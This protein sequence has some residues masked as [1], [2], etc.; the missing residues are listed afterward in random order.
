[1]FSSPERL[2]K[3][4][5]MP[6]GISNMLF[7]FISFHSDGMNYIQEGALFTAS[8]STVLRSDTM[9]SKPICTVPEECWSAQIISSDAEWYKMTTN[10]TY[11]SLLSS[12]SETRILKQKEEFCN[13]AVLCGWAQGGWWK[14]W[15]SRFSDPPAVLICQYKLEGWDR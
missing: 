14:M 8:I 11:K 15:L 1:M 10:L 3:S 7:S 5:I 9:G 6:N 12:L 13:S 2:F 4:S